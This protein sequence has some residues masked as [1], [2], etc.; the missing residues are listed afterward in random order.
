M[1]KNPNR[2]IDGHFQKRAFMDWQVFALVPPQ[3]LAAGGRS[4]FISA[5]SARLRMRAVTS[6]TGV[7]GWMIGPSSLK[8]S[9]H[10]SRL[11]SNSRIGRP[12]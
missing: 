5:E 7:K 2:H 9:S 8:C 12:E 6:P 3:I 10:E 4:S 11:G 1:A